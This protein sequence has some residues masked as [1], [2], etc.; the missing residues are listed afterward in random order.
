MTSRLHDQPRTQHPE[1]RNRTVRWVAAYACGVAWAGADLRASS[2]EIL[3]ATHGD[4]T[5]IEAALEII[6]HLHTVDERHRRRARSVLQRVLAS[7]AVA[8]E[9]PYLTERGTQ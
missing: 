1:R 8:E 9:G 2:D 3:D 5:A 4:R 6:E 7:G